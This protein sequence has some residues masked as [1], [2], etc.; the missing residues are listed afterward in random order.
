[1]PY[2]PRPEPTSRD[3]EDVRF[4][5]ATIRFRT[6]LAPDAAAIAFLSVSYQAARAASA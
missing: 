1:M 4:W 3:R 6:I 5:P 2:Q